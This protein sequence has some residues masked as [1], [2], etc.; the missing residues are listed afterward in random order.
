MYFHLKREKEGM[1]IDRIGL[2]KF[3]YPLEKSSF[4]NKCLTRKKSSDFFYNKILYIIVLQTII[5]KKKCIKHSIIRF[6]Q[7]TE[8][9]PKN[10]F[11]FL[12][13][14][15]KFSPPLNICLSVSRC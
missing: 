1:E 5:K 14:N 10:L 6:S 15:K 9:V 2:E 12:N 3:R 8:N 4:E 7:L 11:Y 13:Q